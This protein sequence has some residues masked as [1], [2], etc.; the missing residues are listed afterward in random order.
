LASDQVRRERRERRE[1]GSDRNQ[2][3]RQEHSSFRTAVSHNPEY[4]HSFAQGLQGC[5]R[6][7]E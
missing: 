5:P 2:G 7:P 6:R 1:Q 4:L 3:V